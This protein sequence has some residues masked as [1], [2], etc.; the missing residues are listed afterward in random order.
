MDMGAEKLGGV[1]AKKKLTKVEWQGCELKVLLHDW[2]PEICMKISALEKELALKCGQLWPLPWEAPSSSPSASRPT[3][4]LGEY[5]R[6]RKQVSKYLADVGATSSK[7]C[8]MSIPEEVGLFHLFGCILRVGDCTLR[9][10]HER[11]R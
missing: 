11:R 3:M 8:H 6:C 5:N 4:S 1:D 10:S 9:T 2:R 7:E